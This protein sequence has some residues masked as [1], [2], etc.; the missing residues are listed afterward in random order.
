[1]EHYRHTTNGIIYLSTNSKQYIILQWIPSRK[2]MKGHGVTNPITITT[3][4]K[5]QNESN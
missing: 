3:D 1:M 4:K 5:S 2:N